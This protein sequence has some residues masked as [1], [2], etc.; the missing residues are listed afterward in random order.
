MMLPSKPCEEV[1]VFET[2]SIAI[3]GLEKYVQMNIWN[4]CNGCFRKLLQA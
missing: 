2:G 4:D 3:R 1:N